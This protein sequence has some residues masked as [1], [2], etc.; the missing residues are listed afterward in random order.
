MPEL[1][2]DDGIIELDVNGN[3]ML[4]FNPADLN[5]YQRL[6]TLLRELPELEKKYAAEVDATSAQRPNPES[7]SSSEVVELAGEDLDK[8]KEIDAEVKKKLAWVFGPG[9]DFDQLLGGINIMS[10]GRNGERAITNFL[11]AITPYLKDGMKR[12]MQDAA[13]DAVSEAKKDRAKRVNQ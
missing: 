2:F 3:G 6:C 12:H 10:P 5:V 1:K 11:N 9:N 7:L 4:R 13:A 8:A